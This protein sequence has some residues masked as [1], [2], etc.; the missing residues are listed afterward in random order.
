MDQRTGVD[1]TE[2]LLDVL[3]GYSG[4]GFCHRQGYTPIRMLGE[5][6]PNPRIPGLIQKSPTNYTKEAL[7]AG[8]EG[9]VFLT[10][11][12]TADGTVSD[13]KVV[14]GL[15]LG[16]DEKAVENLQTWRFMPPVRNGEPTPVNVRFEIRFNLPRSN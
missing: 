6:S 10:G 5:K 11:T 4:S 13:I 9:F 7:Q 16:L 14:K 1:R 3:A 15:G 12:I 2:R 8:L